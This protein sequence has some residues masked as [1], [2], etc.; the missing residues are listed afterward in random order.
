MALI[1]ATYVSSTQFT[2]AND[3]TTDFVP[4]TALYMD[5]GADGIKYGFVN[6]S[7]YGSPN[8]T[9]YLESNE[10]QA[11]TSNLTGVYFSRVKQ[12][13]AAGNIP[14]QLFV[15]QRGHKSGFGLS[16]KD[17]DEIYI[18]A[19][20]IHIDD[21]SAENIYFNPS[22]ITK[23]LTSLSVSTWYAIYVKPPTNGLTLSSTEIDYAAVS[24][25][26]TKN[27]LKRGW[28]HPSSTSWRCIGFVKTD[29][30]GNILPFI[31]NGRSILLENN[32]NVYSGA[33]S[34]TWATATMDIPV[35]EISAIA[36][37]T[38]FFNNAAAWAVWRKKGSSGSGHYCAFVS[39]V[40]GAWGSSPVYMAC[41][42]NKQVEVS[43]SEASANTV[44]VRNSGYVLDDWM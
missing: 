20:S 2:V 44:Y 14:L 9:I 43:T 13:E 25:A 3:M 34:V 31:R 4:G 36:M 39:S 7:S 23:Q 11:I 18:D 21:G 12:K 40:T 41:D 28:Y 37:M 10:S 38:I 5:C 27:Q 29:S 26:P 24:S 35:G 15:S 22:Q 32:P 16:Y 42:S 6:Y 33:P 30:S 1:S 17:A 19:G 8:T